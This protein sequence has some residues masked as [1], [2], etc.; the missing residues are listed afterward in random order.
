MLIK[1]YASRRGKIFVR[2]VY[3]VHSRDQ[4][5]A[6]AAVY[7]YIIIYIMYSIIYTSYIIII[8]KFPLRDP[9]VLT[10]RQLNQGGGQYIIYS[11]F[12]LK[13]FLLS[14]PRGLFVEKRFASK[15]PAW[16]YNNI[17]CIT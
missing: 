15:S 1:L 10:M 14:D 9:A 4:T 3:R 11:F 8:P 5:S 16:L 2:T 7:I 6:A 13:H 17:S 12:S